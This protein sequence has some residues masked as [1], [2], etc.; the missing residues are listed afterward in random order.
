[1]VPTIRSLSFCLMVLLTAAS[2]AAAP[3]PVRA[4]QSGSGGQAKEEAPR[5]T[6]KGRITY[7][8]KMEAYMVTGVEPPHEHYFILNANPAVL[9]PLVQKEA[10]VSIEGVLPQ[11]AEFIRIEKLNGK[12]YSG[13]P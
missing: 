3:V 4:Q 1:M 5:L 11:G 9:D 10:A 8:K 13:S 6:L 2:V 12:P 7:E